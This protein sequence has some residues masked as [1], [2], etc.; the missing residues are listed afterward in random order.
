MPKAGVTVSNLSLPLQSLHDVPAPATCDLDVMPRPV[1]VLAAA[2]IEENFHVVE[3]L[4]ARL[5]NEEVR[6]AEAVNHS[7][8]LVD[9]LLLLRLASDLEGLAKAD[10]VIDA[11]ALPSVLA[12]V[13]GS[14][15]SLQLVQH[16][17]IGTINLLEYCKRHRAGLV[18]LSTSRVYS[19]EALNSLCLTAKDDAFQLDESAESSE[20]VSAK[21][22]VES[23]STEAPVSLYG[24]TKLASETLAKEYGLAFD[25]PVLINRC[26]VLAGAGQFGRPDQGIF[27]FWLHSHRYRQSLRYIGFG[28]QGYQVRDCLNV[29]DL[30]RLVSQQ[31]R[32]ADST[33]APTTIHVSGGAENSISLSQLTTWCDERFGSH[34]V[35]SS[36][37]ERPFDLPWVVLDSS[38]AHQHW[39]WQPEISL[40]ETLEEIAT[41]AD[42]NPDWLELSR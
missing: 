27:T 28:G 41:H 22:I 39:D 20:L 24:A 6:P 5:G 33:E 1:R 18:L 2:V 37:E 42:A 35:Q 9:S 17:L 21:G 34:P 23:F 3:D 26:G 13:D 16:N 14:S 25:F 30:S 31:I 12:G 15:S 19:I 40:E 4:V 38:L 10:W 8:K 11:A 7:D 32:D 36:T 29:R